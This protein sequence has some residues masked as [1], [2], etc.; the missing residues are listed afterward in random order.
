LAAFKLVHV[1]GII[2]GGYECIKAAGL[3]FW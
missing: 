2:D 1:H 3:F